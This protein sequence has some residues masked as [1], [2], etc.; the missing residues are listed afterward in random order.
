MPTLTT[1]GTLVLFGYLGPLDPALN[2]VPLVVNR[3]AV[4]GSLNGSIA[5]NQEM[6]DVC[7]EHG[8]TSDP[9][10]Y[11]LCFG[12]MLRRTLSTP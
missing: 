4:A 5:E 8:I 10:M 11:C 3:K 1:D 9:R 6:L 7:G 2:S 12:A